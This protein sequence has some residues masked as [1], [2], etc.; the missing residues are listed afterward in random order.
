MTLG[1][2]IR[3]L[4]EQKDLSLREF[5]TKVGISAAHQSDIELGRRFPSDDLLRKIA[6]A[7]S[8]DFE[9]LKTFDSRAPIE[10]M[11]KRA[12]IDPAY[13]FALRTLIDKKIT[14]AEILNF[15]KRKP[16]R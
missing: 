8:E 11:R 12:E 6:K 5:A 1:Q 14:A 2:R 4:R 3:I 9:E 13:G 10:D 7:L 16:E 15:A